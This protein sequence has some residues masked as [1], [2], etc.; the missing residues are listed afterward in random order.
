MAPR[1]NAS[2]QMQ[3]QFTQG[4]PVNV[5]L[6]ADPQ[7]IQALQR[8]G[9]G[10]KTTLASASRTASRTGAVTKRKKRRK[11]ASTASLGGYI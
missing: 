11:K 7:L 3:H 1:K 4:I 10:T 6:H 5:M 9:M 8:L 2:Q